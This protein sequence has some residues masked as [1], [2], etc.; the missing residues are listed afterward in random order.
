LARIQD[1]CPRFAQH[2][3]AIS[4]VSGGSLGGS[5]FAA[6]AATRAKNE[7]K[8]ECR[9]ELNSGGYLQEATEKFF[10]HDLLTPLLA[11]G[12]YP[13]LLQRLLP[14]RVQSFDR[15]QHLERAMEAAWA[16]AVPESPAA[17]QTT[18]RGLWSTRGSAPALVLNTTEVRSGGVEP[19][20]PFYLELDAYGSQ[21]ELWLGTDIPLRVSTAIGMSARFPWLTP[22]AGLSL[23]RGESRPE[24]W[25]FVDGAYFEN[26]GIETAHQLILGLQS[27]IERRNKQ[28]GREAN[29]VVVPVE[30]RNQSV[31][32]AFRLLSLRTLDSVDT[33]SVHGELS[34]PIAA[35]LNARFKRASLAR[36]YA[37]ASLCPNCRLGEISLAD[38]FREIILDFREHTLPLGWILSR[39]SLEYVRANLKESSDCP[40]PLG[41]TAHVAADAHNVNSCFYQSIVQDLS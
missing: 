10:R 31:R 4:A 37:R 23:D 35:L 14:W 27:A 33:T 19:I 1:N 12:M 38:S 20:A 34:T 25:Q 9:P 21:T 39:Q 5:I 2:L 24:S 30:G 40:I 41:S 7:Q 32:V 15:A 13:D 16:S 3:F 26:S 6:L 29:E 36:F 22:P 18:V 17:L 11:A 28:P 8:A